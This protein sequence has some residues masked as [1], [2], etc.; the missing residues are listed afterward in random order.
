MRRFA[1]VYHLTRCLGAG[2]VLGSCSTRKHLRSNAL[3]G[4][5]RPV[6]PHAMPG[7]VR[8]L[9]DP[10]HSS[11][12]S[13]G[14]TCA[15]TKTED[16]K[17]LQARTAG[18]GNADT[19]PASQPDGGAGGAEHLGPRGKRRAQRAGTWRAKTSLALSHYDWF[20]PMSSPYR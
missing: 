17:H 11:L 4:Q 2:L 8:S 18:A 6:T 14:G 12:V 5:P 19:E 1:R 15:V 10:H 16:T 13:L 20:V 3:D 9:P 7:C